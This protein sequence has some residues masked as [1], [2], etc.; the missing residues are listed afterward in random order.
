MN[1]D[2]FMVCWLCFIL[3]WMVPVSYDL[4][5]LGREI[6]RTQEKLNDSSAR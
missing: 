1:F 4:Y 5:K 3:G 2:L 6:K